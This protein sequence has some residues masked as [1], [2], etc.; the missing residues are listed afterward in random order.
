MGTSKS[1]VELAAKLTAAHTAIGLASTRGVEAGAI[2]FKDAANAAFPSF[3][4][5][6][7][8]S[9]RKV[10]ARYN[11]G[12]YEGGGKYLVYMTG[13]AQLYNN[14][15]KPHPIP[16]LAGARSKKLFGPAFGGEN[17]KKL[18]LPGGAVRSHVFHPGTKGHHAWE[19]T[20]SVMVPLIPKI[21]EA[22]V[23]GALRTIF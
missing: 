9:G 5:G 7:G 4:R 6:V 15:T 10:S 8:K 16:K 13:P 14:D 23:V 11:G 12:K 18:M 22:G 1:P 19:K 17:T 20:E 3:M 2:A 21:I